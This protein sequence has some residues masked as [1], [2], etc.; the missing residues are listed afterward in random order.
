MSLD[1][2]SHTSHPGGPGPEEL[3][4]S[5]YALKI[6]DIDVLVISDGVLLLPGAMVA[7][8]AAPAVRAAWLKDMF[9][10]PDA[11]DWALNVVLVR[12]GG[13]TILVDAGFGEEFPGFPK[14]GRL[15]LRLEAAGIDLSSVTD[16]VL[17][18]MHMDH[19]GGLLIDGVKERLRPDLRI[20]VAAAEVKFWEAP[21]FS[22]VSMPPG[23]PDALRA[24]AEHF[25]KEYHS[26]FRLFDET[27]EVAPGVVVQRTGG[28][29]PG[30]SVVRVASRGD[31]LT[32]AGD[33]VFQGG[34]EHPDWFNGFEHDPEE[35]TRVR[36]R[37]LRELAG[38][39]ELLVATHLP[40]PSVCHVLVDG[41]AF[42]CVPVNWDY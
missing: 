19:V 38:T 40:F 32:F 27:Q 12:S 21:D 39:G 7:Y 3:V 17:T 8:N 20:H 11:F 1:Y 13:K 18:H 6:G 34:F 25:V 22:H 16:V 37:L 30:H 24:S 23:F 5:R 4:P 36:I 33:L 15:G 28:H 2:T 9:L 35:A 29:T 26:Q 31:R 10:P 42:R 41:D 14:S